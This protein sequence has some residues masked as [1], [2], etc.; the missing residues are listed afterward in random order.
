MPSRLD[1]LPTGTWFPILCGLLVAC[2]TLGAGLFMDDALARVKLL[3]LDTPW[4]PA[5]WWDLYTFARPDLNADLLAAGH[6]P[7]W[8]A[9]ELKMTFFR[10]LS[11][12][13]HHLDYALWPDSAW[14][15]HLHSVLWYGGTVALAAVLFRQIHGARRASRIAALAFAVAT[16]HVLTVGWLSGRN[17]LIAFVLSG[18]VLYTHVRSLDDRRLRVVA[19]LLF[20]V[21]LLAGE[22]ALA[23]LGYVAAWHLCIDT[24]KWTTRLS[25][26]LPYL[27][28]VLIWRW[29]YVDA[30]FG[31]AGTA[32]YHDPSSDPG[33]FLR[34][35]AMHLPVLVLGRWLPIPLDFWSIIPASAQWAV[36]GA[37]VALMLG[38]WRALRALLQTPIARFWFVGMLLALLP[39]CATVPMDRLT[40]FAG[41]GFAGLIGLIAER[42]SSRA[43]TVCLTFYLP[44]A[45]IF[46]L[47]R[48]LTLALNFAPATNGVAQA[49]ADDAVPQQTFVYV[50][51]TFHRIHY[52]T[53]MRMAA[54]QV[55]PKRA[56]MLTSMGQTA[57]LTRI[58]AH[59]VEV[60]PDGGFMHLGVDR[61]HR[62]ASQRFAEG[63]RVQLPDLSVEVRA[64]TADGR[65]QRAVF[66]FREAL[67]SE[68]LRW[69]QV[70]PGEL[71]FLDCSTQRF[72]LPPP[73][74]SVVIRS[75]L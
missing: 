66:R 12:L 73:G 22:A 40:F 25:A 69:L 67:E 56:V 51:S 42:A 6:H 60:E 62:R 61:I 41:L 36:V 20:A 16:P 11:A 9:P 57:R 26:G 63:D 72:T 10:P 4:S 58:D 30:G 64:V 7:W 3:D 21:S 31:T 54:G 29:L 44:L 32:I 45:A 18:L 14:W 5:A 43:R 75:V 70:V 53:L 71:G 23:M 34:A 55:A 37:G 47:G 46:G 2:S 65:P 50:N 49:P 1:R 28:I 17:T 39:F 19:P 74:E 8:A 35:Q 38:L 48:G 15:Q 68:Q 24:R 27:L 33:D 52:T 59:T 13:T